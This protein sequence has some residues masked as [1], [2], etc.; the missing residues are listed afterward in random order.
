MEL[1]KLGIVEDE[2]LIREN[3]EIFFETQP[4]TEILFLADSM[5]S[6]LEQLKTIKDLDCIILDIGLPGM[7]ALDGIRHIRTL[8][9]NLD[10]IILTSFDDSERIFKALSNGAAAYISKKTSHI[11]IKEAIFSVHRGGSFMSPIIARKVFDYFSP[12]K[13]SSIKALTPRQTQIV[14][15]IIEGLSYKMIAE[16]YSISIETVRDHIKKIYRNLEVNSKMELVQKRLNG[17]I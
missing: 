10:I 16:K 14:D 8:E 3:L 2:D 4:D 1:L 5:E 17:D 6:C 7:S 9:P 11:K 13:E 12:K 15:A